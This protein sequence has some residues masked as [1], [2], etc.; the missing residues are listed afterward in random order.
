MAASN[1]HLHREGSASQL[2]EDPSRIAIIQEG[3]KN[4]EVYIVPSGI[5]ESLLT[6]I[7]EHLAT[8]GKSSIANYHPIEANCPNFHR[9]NR[10]DERAYVKG[11]FHQFSFFP[12]N[13][14]AF[15]LFSL[16]APVFQLKN[17]ISG[18][19]ADRYLNRI[20]YD[21]CCSRISFQFYPKGG[22]ALNRHRDPVDK[23]QLTVP[24]MQ[25]SRK[26]KDYFEGGGYVQTPDGNDLIGDDY[27]QIGDI[28]FFNA[29]SEH[30]VHPID[31]ND[32]SHWTSFE[33]RWIALFAVNKLSSSSGIDDAEEIVLPESSI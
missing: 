3:I 12:W 24:I 23:H 8:I 29:R 25:L 10:W 11:C 13:Q 2:L 15:D 18:I 31:A 16:F 30:G 26:S 19:P 1:I 28:I 5:P 9:I 21:N 7:R 32:Q 27:A 22:G 14:D 20:P 17:L 4:G 6:Q 33:G